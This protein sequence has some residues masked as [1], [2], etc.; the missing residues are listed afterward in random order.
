AVAMYAFLVCLVV[1]ELR[2]PRWQ[3]W[4][5]GLLAAVF[6]TLIGLS[7]VY[8]G[9]HYPTDVIAGFLLGVPWLLV[10]LSRYR[11][12]QPEPRPAA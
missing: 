7:R 2:L 9:T 1:W 3:A 12:G 10:V 5:L 4:V 11:K 6:I 8:L